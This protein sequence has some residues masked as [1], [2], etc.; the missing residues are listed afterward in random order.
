MTE[1]IHREESYRIVG[2]CFE[3][4]NEIGSGFLEAVYQE[5][6]AMEFV[7]L[8]IP[9]VAKPRLELAYKGQT[10]VQ[11]YEPD[12]LCFG[13]IVIE[14]KA[15]KGLANEHYAQVINYLK[16]SGHKLGLLINFGSHPKLEYKRL[17]NQ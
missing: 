11:T 2:A 4:Y 7:R 3:V 17:L 8:G 9:F 12:F 5:C 14:L 1:L 6:L 15:V 13:S 10:L 16:A